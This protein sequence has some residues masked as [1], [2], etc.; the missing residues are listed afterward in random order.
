MF[1]LESVESDEARVSINPYQPPSL[2]SQAVGVLSG[3]RDDLRAVAKYQKGIIVC[4]LVYLILVIVQF[5]LPPDLRPILGLLLIP[6]GIIG[7]VFVFLLSTKVY[8]TPLGIVFG[9][10]T[11]VPC[12][13]LIMLLVVNGKATS[14]LK[15]NG[16]QVSLLGANMSQL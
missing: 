6:L 3:T 7:T 12:V 8:G 11:L 13:G 15:Q 5:A 2:E 1:F 14:V 4:I 10:L 16:I 9:L